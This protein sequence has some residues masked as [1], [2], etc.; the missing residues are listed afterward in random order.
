M[1]LQDSQGDHHL[2]CALLLLPQGWPVLVV[3]CRCLVGTK[4]RGLCVMWG[5]SS[6]SL[7]ARREKV[8]TARSGLPWSK[9]A[10][11]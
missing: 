4:H 10:V 1:D 8:A 7:R 6:Q 9:D 3:P 2:T 5:R 11:K